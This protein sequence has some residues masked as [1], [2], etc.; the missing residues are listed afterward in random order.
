M[1]LYTLADLSSDWINPILGI[2]L[3]LERGGLRKALPF[4]LRATLSLL[5]AVGLAELGKKFQI[6]PGHQGFPSGHTTFAATSTTLLFLRRGP[7]WLLVGIPL[8]LLMMASLIYGHW[9]SLGDTLGAVVLSL[10]VSLLL[11]KLTRGSRG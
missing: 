6:W 8:T 10:S 9:H 3:L 5:L 2:L 4:W 7:R 1:T 11:W